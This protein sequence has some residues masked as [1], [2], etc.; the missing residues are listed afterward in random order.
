MGVS[1]ILTQRVVSVVISI[2]IISCGSSGGGNSGSNAIPESTA[3]IYETTKALDD[4]T[5][6]VL[7]SVSA[8][9]SIFTFRETTD[10][11]QSL[12]VDDIIIAGV[13]DETPQGAI[14]KVATIYES[15]GQTIMVTTE[16]GL[17]DAFEELHLQETITMDSNIIYQ[18]GILQKSALQKS[19]IVAAQKTVTATGNVSVKDNNVRFSLSGQYDATVDVDFDFSPVFDLTIDISGGKL[20]E[21]KLE[22]RGDTT[23]DLDATFNAYA[24]LDITKEKSLLPAP[25]QLFVVQVVIPVF[26]VPVPVIITG[27]FDIK[28]GISFTSGGQLNAGFGFTSTYDAA[29]GFIYHPSGN[30][31]LSTINTFDYTFYPNI[32]ANSAIVFSLTPYVTPQIGTYLYTAVGPFIDLKAYGKGSAVIGSDAY[33]EA[34]YGITG[35]LGG[36]LKIKS[37]TLFSLNYTLFNEYYSQPSWRYDFNTPPTASISSP[38]TSATYTVGETITFTGSGSDDEDG[39]LSG[40]SLAWT[41][42][43]DGQIGTGTSFTTSTLSAGTHSITLTAT[44]SDGATGSASVSITVSA[45][46]VISHLPDTGQTKCYDNTSEFGI[47]CPSVGGAFYGQDAQYTINPMSFTDNGDGTVTDNVTGLMWQQE[48]DNIKRTDAEAVT[49]CRDLGLSTYSD[50]RV[51]T[52]KELISI[53][54]Y[55]TDSP[56]IHSIYFPN[57]NY[58]LSQYDYTLN[59]YRTSTKY[60]RGGGFWYVDFR[61]GRAIT[62]IGG[63]GSLYV[64]CVRGDQL[65]NPSFTDNNDGTVTDNVTGLMWQKED[66]DNVRDWEAALS[67]CESL[68]LAGFSDWR[69]PNIKELD[70]IT[71]DEQAWLDTS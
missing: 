27:E 66:D 29:A 12:S 50:W 32:T 24:A 42:S 59:W 11:L 46:G 3:K 31:E 15:G 52:K 64:R 17:E 48:D 68:S 47:T 34:G 49:Y 28:A 51:P 60:V 7:A 70:S 13:S 43:I 20:E 58:K 57:T 41:S 8:D 40:A 67:Y 61:Y 19:V 69:L 39:Q 6:K 5:F 18:N 63:D 9:G 10:Q 26:G 1:A 53:V 22:V 37:T 14:R 71:D 45:V 21:F 38:T 2:T 25:I 16:A 33:L 4:S 30:P 44:D 54:N 55:G 35:S 23:F 56:A 65:P 36:E 62:G